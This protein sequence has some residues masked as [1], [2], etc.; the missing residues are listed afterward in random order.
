L[1]SLLAREFV[2]Q[3]ECS[4]EK[5]R[6]FSNQEGVNYISIHISVPS[7]AIPGSDVKDPCPLDAMPYHITCSYIISN[8]NKCVSIFLLLE[9]FPISTDANA[10]P[11]R[12]KQL[13]WSAPLDDVDTMNPL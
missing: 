2:P 1:I 12:R 6:I 3:I 5:S 4:P 9:S 10:G 8:A 13:F 7:D 11:W